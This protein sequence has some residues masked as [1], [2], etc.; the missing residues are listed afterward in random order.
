MSRLARPGVDTALQPIWDA[1]PS[2]AII[3]PVLAQITRAARPA[4]IFSALLAAMDE[5][6]DAADFAAMRALRE[7]PL[8]AAAVKDGRLSMALALG[9]T[10]FSEAVQQEA[11]E[12][13]YA[14]IADGAGPRAFPPADRI[15]SIAKTFPET[16]E[17][18]AALATHL[19]RGGRA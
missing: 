2:S 3:D 6:S 9:L 19:G 4:E 7:A 16:A 12:A 14:L 10:S 8:R 13:V 18:M 11:C 17:T 5:G 15:R 1:D